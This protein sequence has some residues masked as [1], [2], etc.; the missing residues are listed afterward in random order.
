M[1]VP[2]L[3]G[4]QREARDNDERI[5]RA[6]GEVF[7][8]NPEAKM[9]D[10]ANAAE[11]GVASLYRRYPDKDSL[12]RALCVNTMHAI[13]S[14]SRD[15]AKKDPTLANVTTFLLEAVATGAG[16]LL[17][18]AG[19]FEPG[20]EV[21]ATAGEMFAAI[22]ELLSAAQQA[23]SL[24]DDLCAADINHVFTMLHSITADNAQ[25]RDEL[26]Q[27]YLDLIITGATPTQ[28][29]HRLTGPPPTQKEIAQTW[30]PLASN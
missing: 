4:R 5:L 3:R 22:G 8:T 18:I 1:A 12:V 19:S 28:R 16:S 27:R 29:H 17:S 25:R 2:V 6:A 14:L 23:Q 9:I 20:H 15:A 13:T 10:I 7:L 26:R 11:V 30:R 21:N 24:R